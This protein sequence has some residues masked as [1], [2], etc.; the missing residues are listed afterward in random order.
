MSEEDDERGGM[1]RVN[2]NFDEKNKNPQGKPLADYQPD[3]KKKHRIVEGDPN[4]MDGSLSINGSGKGRWRLIFPGNIKVW[5]RA[6]GAKYEEVVSLRFSPEEEIPFFCQLNVEGIKGSQVTNDVRIVLEFVPTGSEKAYRDSVLLTV[7]ETR[8]A[9]TFD[10]GPLPKKTEK[11]VKAL[12]R[13]YVEGKPVK[14]AFFQIGTQIH[15]FPDLVRSV[16]K[17]RHLVLNHTQHHE[18][19]GY[20]MLNT[21]EIRNAILLCEEEIRNTLGKEPNK[22]IRTR[23]LRQDLR[24]EKEAKRLGYKIC[25]GELLYDWDSTATVDGIQKRAEKI[26]E[27]WNTRDNPRLN[28]Y[29]ALLIFH[30]FPQVTYNHIGEIISYLQDQGFVLVNFDPE[31]AY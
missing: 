14:A 15:K 27:G 20:T 11:I 23:S 21:E 25:V 16:D 24:F 6:N 2:A 3:R 28:P 30:E 4:L 8:F 9:V 29:P 22:I 10:D 26:L 31:L 5:R 13:F 1:I 12:K 7:V 19:Y 17:N 18:R